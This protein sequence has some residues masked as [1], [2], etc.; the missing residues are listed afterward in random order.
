MDYTLHIIQVDTEQTWAG[1][2]KTTVPPVIAFN[3]NL[4]FTEQIH[5]EKCKH[6]PDLLPW[7][8]G[9]GGWGDY[10]PGE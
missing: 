4:S 3:E 10:D 1:T 2:N 8:S 6:D 5:Q 7:L 9:I